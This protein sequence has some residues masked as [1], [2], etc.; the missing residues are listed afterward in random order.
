MLTIRPAISPVDHLLRHMLGEDVRRADIDVDLVLPLVVG[1][2]PEVAADAHAGVVDQDVDHWDGRD[3]R[4]RQAMRLGVIRQIGRDTDRV[5]SDLLDCR[6][7]LGDRLL[8]PAADDDRGALPRKP[9]GS[10]PAQTAGAPG[11]QCPLSSQRVAHGLLPRD[12]ITVSR[13]P[14]A[15]LAPVRSGIELLGCPVQLTW[16][17]STMMMD[18]EIPYAAPESTDPAPL[19]LGADLCPALPGGGRDARV[20]DRQPTRLL[21]QLGD[22]HRCGTCSH[23][24]PIHRVMSSR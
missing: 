3:R 9:L 14:T 17:D 23:S 4:L 21:L 18:R 22:I 15:R 11:H 5:R 8:L 24:S 6:D 20:A 12:R 13:H 7:A 16:I 2:V 10:G 1:H 19:P